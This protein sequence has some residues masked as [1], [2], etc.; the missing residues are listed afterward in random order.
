V[1][2]FV[3]ISYDCSSNHVLDVG[4]IQTSVQR[5]TGLLFLRVKRKPSVT[6]HSS[7]LWRLRI[8]GAINPLFPTPAWYAQGRLYCFQFIRPSLNV[9]MSLL[10]V[11]C[12]SNSDISV[13]QVVTLYSIHNEFKSWEHNPQ[14]ISQKLP[15]Y[16]YYTNYEQSNPLPHNRL[17]FSANHF[18]LYMKEISLLWRWR[19]RVQPKGLCQPTGRKN[20]D[21]FL[22]PILFE[23]M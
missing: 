15:H 20:S 12:R 10:T 19:Q 4:A 3:E 16:L 5:I 22:P 17:S 9:N 18:R 23:S 2:S 14:S 7:L 8:T 13:I 6:A 1:T 11:R 21:F